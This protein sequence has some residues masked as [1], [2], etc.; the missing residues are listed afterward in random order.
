ML[1]NTYN[2]IWSQKGKNIKIY[3]NYD[4]FVIYL[5][6]VYIYIWYWMEIYQIINSNSL[7][8]V[9]LK[10]IAIFFFAFFY[11]PRFLWAKMYYYCNQ[12][13]CKCYFKWSAIAVRVW[14]FRS[15]VTPEL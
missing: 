3:V 11:I 12:K 6:N 8:K 14:K 10:M 5:H 1:E 4:Y 15:V 7:R 13:N 2:L 9:T